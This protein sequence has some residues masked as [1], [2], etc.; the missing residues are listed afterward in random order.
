VN[1]LWKEMFGLG[2][3]EPVN[4]FD[5]TKLETQPTHP[6]LLEA[7]TDEFIAK[8]YSLRAILRTM[9]V[10]NAY[11][12]SA[13]Y[14]PTVWNES[15]VPYFARRYPRRMMAEAAFDALATATSVPASFT[16]AGMNNVAKAMQLPDPL[17]GRRAGATPFINNFGRGDRDDNARSNDSSISQALAMMNDQNIT[18]RVK[19]ATANSTVSKV[20]AATSDPA[21]IVEE[22]YL[23]T[24][25]RKPT[26][27]ESQAAVD[28]LKAGTLTERTEDL[29][30][31]LLN[32]LEFLF[33]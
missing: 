29:Q 19:R 14:T 11:Q 17:E 22:L 24:L 16:V 6:A 32:S 1:Y 4:A 31:V 18:L 10:S 5:L 15:W 12:L 26:S 23:A 27:G 7:L 25:S 20:L 28:Y 2:L 3:V 33:Q 8:G 21:A 9:A 13:H 30:F